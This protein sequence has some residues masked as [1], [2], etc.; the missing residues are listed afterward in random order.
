MSNIYYEKVLQKKSLHVALTLDSHN[1]LKIECAKRNLS[2][3]EVIEGFAQKLA[4]ADTNFL[5]LL[6][7]INN[8]KKQGNNRNTLRKSEINNIYDLLEND[9]E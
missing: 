3:Q 9:K 4:I 8:D 7:E 5:S 6:D 2:M 1:A